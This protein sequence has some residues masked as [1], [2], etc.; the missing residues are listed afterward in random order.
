MKK[1]AHFDHLH[2]STGKDDEEERNDGIYAGI[3]APNDDLTMHQRHR[4]DL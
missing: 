4:F 3:D 2:G 1:T